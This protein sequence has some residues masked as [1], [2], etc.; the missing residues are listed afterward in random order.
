MKIKEK[1]IRK[2]RKRGRKSKSK[3]IT[4]DYQRKRRG[5]KKGKRG[6]PAKI[7]TKDR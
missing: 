5:R 7:N 3:R 2:G 4:F 6:R 1:A